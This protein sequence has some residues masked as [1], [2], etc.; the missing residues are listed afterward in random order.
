MHENIET[1]FTAWFER[2]YLNNGYKMSKPPR[3]RL[4]VSD[5]LHREAE[6]ALDKGQSH[7]L[8]NVMRLGDGDRLSVF[9]GT[10]GEWLAGIKKAG[11]REVVLQLVEVTRGQ[12][13]GP[14][15]DYYFA[16]LKKARLDYMAQKAT[17]LGAAR[18]C[19]V[20]TKYCQVERV[21]LERLRANAIEAAEQCG[22]LFVPEVLEPQRIDQLL[23]GWDD[24]RALI[25]CDES[26]GRE[27]PLETLAGIECD[28]WGVLI[29]PE[30]GF[31]EDERALLAEQ[32][33][34][35]P[36]S[37]GPRIMRADTAA[38]AALSLLNAVVGDWS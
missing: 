5:P 37:L 9:N 33:F 11:K 12:T 18:L 34:V 6:V 17:E 36:L 30:G 16:P 4:F 8:L 29:G 31:S 1:L 28:K 38:V 27:N 24:T 22:I 32:R 13:Y 7:Y 3:V 23:A 26:R 19:P 21:N 25:F 35:T 14:D 2:Q 20:I 15:I 10:D